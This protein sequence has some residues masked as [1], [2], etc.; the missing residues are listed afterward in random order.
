MQTLDPGTKSAAG[1]GAFAKRMKGVGLPNEH[2]LLR[3][4]DPLLSP[5]LQLV[6]E[7]LPLDAVADQLAADFV[8]DRLPPVP[9][10]A[11]AAG[12]GAAAQPS[13]KKGSKKRSR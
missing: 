8:H 11:A 10:A 6:V 5:P 4:S 7:Q 2:S 13:G 12:A 1:C 3:H 9:A